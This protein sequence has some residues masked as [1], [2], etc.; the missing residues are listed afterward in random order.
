MAFPYEMQTRRHSPP[1][2]NLAP[3]SV[4]NTAT[5]QPSYWEA[6]GGLPLGTQSGPLGGP[7]CPR[8]PHLSC[9]PLLAHCGQPGPRP[10]LLRAL[11]RALRWPCPPWCASLRL[12]WVVLSRGT[13][14]SSRL[15]FTKVYILRSPH[16]HGLPHSPFLP[17]SFSL[18]QP[19]AGMVSLV[20]C[21]VNSWAW[22]SAWYLPFSGFS[23]PV[24]RCLMGG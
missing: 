2:P 17:H 11:L 3:L 21:S 5:R 23:D 20:I 4:L 10:A 16:L 6:P 7:T 8:R 12:T 19:P 13:R 9:A 1:T 15:L 18:A 14:P 22:D 24:R